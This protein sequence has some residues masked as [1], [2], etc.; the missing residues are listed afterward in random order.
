MENLSTFV[1]YSKELDYLLVIDIERDRIILHPEFP[2]KIC[3]VVDDISNPP[4][5]IKILPLD[6]IGDL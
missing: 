2:D 1:Y 4:L 5:C 6:Y 3:L